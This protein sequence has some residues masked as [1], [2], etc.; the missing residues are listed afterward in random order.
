[1]PPGTSCQQRGEAFRV[2]VLKDFA[3]SLF[4]RDALE[5]ALRTT[6]SSAIPLSPVWVSRQRRQQY[7]KWPKVVG[8]GRFIYFLCFGRAGP[9]EPACADMYPCSSTEGVIQVRLHSASCQES[10]GSIHLYACSL[11]GKMHGAP[12]E[13]TEW[14]L[15][16]C[17]DLYVC[18]HSRPQ[19][20]ANLHLRGAREA[21][22]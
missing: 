22:Q 14:E 7:L 19:Q 20:K 15:S 21:E 2:C 3:V 1:M 9:H 17:A 10:K 18:R 5:Q 11:R 4:S 8:L 13:D 16:A 6:R 12:C